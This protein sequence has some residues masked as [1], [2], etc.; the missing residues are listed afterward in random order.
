MSDACD[1]Y[2]ADLCELLTSDKLTLF[3]MWLHCQPLERVTLFAEDKKFLSRERVQLGR[4]VGLTWSAVP[5]VYQRPGS[6]GWPK[7]VPWPN[8]DLRAK[9]DAIINALEEHEV[10]K[11]CRQFRRKAKKQEKEECRTD[12]RPR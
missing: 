10:P 11:W 3:I 12:N 2:R 7:D 1:A 9:L 5:P 8:D 4:M 6:G